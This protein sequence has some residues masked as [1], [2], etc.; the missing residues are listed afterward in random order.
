M[1]FFFI[2]LY[3]RILLITFQ[4][5]NPLPWFPTLFQKSLSSSSVRGRVKPGEY[6]NIAVKIEQHYKKTKQFIIMR[7]ISILMSCATIMLATTSAL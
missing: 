3:L 1:S 5:E 4:Q 6:V 7:K 2:K